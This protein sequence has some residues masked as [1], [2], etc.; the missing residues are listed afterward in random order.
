MKWAA[1]AEI[2]PR[3]EKRR[4]SWERIRPRSNGR[5]PLVSE[6]KDKVF[7]QDSVWPVA[8]KSRTHEPSVIPRT[9]SAAE[10]LDSVREAIRN[11]IPKIEK[12]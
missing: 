4:T 7:A 12:A 11:E 8:E 6:R 3:R 2:I 5:I 9:A 10:A 1:T